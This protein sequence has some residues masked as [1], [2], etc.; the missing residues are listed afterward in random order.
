MTI[1]AINMSFLLVNLMPG[2]SSHGII[3]QEKSDTTAHQS[4]MMKRGVFNLIP[5]NGQQMPG[6]LRPNWNRL[7]KASFLS[8]FRFNGGKRGISIHQIN[9]TIRHLNP[10]TNHFNPT[11]LHTLKLNDLINQKSG[12]KR[13]CKCLNLHTKIS[14]QEAA[15]INNQKRGVF[16]L[17]SNLNK[18]S[19]LSEKLLSMRQ[20]ISNSLKGLKE[21]RGIFNLIPQHLYKASPATQRL[22]RKVSNL[23]LRSRYPQISSYTSRYPPGSRYFSRHSAL[24]RFKQTYPKWSLMTMINYSN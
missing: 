12:P 18:K 15:Q 17:I 11:K 3:N 22:T 23:P 10:T 1:I 8:Q 6:I 7:G 16:N 14:R 4:T 19:G 20:S 9:P 13:N 5:M 21:K 24:P 2:V